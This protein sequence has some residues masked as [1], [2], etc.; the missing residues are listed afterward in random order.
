[1]ID[2]YFAAALAANQVMVFIPGD[3]V[4]QM[5]AADMSAADQPANISV[6]ERW[7]P[8][9]CRT[10]RMVIRWGVIRNPRARNWGE[11]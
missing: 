5:P 2:V 6:G 4:D 3:L 10:C 1:M 7:V 8:A 11:Y 9:W